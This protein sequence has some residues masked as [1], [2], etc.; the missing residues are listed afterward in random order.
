MAVDVQAAHI[1]WEKAKQDSISWPVWEGT[2]DLTI[3]SWGYSAQLARGRLKVKAST[4][5]FLL[6]AASRLS[7]AFRLGAV[8]ERLGV[9]KPLSDQRILFLQGPLAQELY[10]GSLAHW[11]ETLRYI[12]QIGGNALVMDELIDREEIFDLAKAFGIHLI[13]RFSEDRELIYHTTWWVT[14]TIYHDSVSKEFLAYERARVQIQNLAKRLPHGHR[15]VY[16]IDSPTFLQAKQ[17]TLWWYELSL[18]VPPRVV[19]AFSSQ[20]EGKMH[21]LWD[22]IRRSREP[23]GVPLLPVIDAEVPIDVFDGVLSRQI[24]HPIE[25][26]AIQT[27]KFP[28]SFSA[29]GAFEASWGGGLASFW[30]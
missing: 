15:L 22:T 11:E 24:Y 1:A 16:H 9:Q 2:L 7:S 5:A 12:V 20:V 6:H 3:P 4:P 25:G 21:P 18:D 13:C 19:L 23:F 10:R 8:R 14:S 30:L 17:E 26:I 28:V 29:V 27:E